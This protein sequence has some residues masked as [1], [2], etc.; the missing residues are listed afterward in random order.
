MVDTIFNEQTIK[1]HL[2][3]TAEIAVQYLNE[4]MNDFKDLQLIV[5]CINA[6]AEIKAGVPVNNIS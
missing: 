3:Y 5:V 2:A 6:H 4:M 1:C